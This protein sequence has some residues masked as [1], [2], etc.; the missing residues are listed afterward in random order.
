[1]LVYQRVVHNPHPGRVPRVPFLPNQ[2]IPPGAS[3][4]V[5][6]KVRGPSPCGRPV[7]GAL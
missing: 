6:L 2:A 7:R 5:A 4:H 3:L 1:M